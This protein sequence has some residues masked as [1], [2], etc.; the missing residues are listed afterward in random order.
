[1]K[2]YRTVLHS[3]ISG[4]ATTFV[5]TRVGI[6]TKCHSYYISNVPPY[7]CTSPHV[8]TSDDMIYHDAT[9]C[10]KLPVSYFP[11]QHGYL[12]P[13]LILRIT[14]SQKHIFRLGFLKP[15]LVPIMLSDTENNVIPGL[16]S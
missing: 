15:L 9:A 14:Q 13:H 4:E 8:I 11:Q 6:V 1:M 3:I 12:R 2:R 5:I 16:Y 7:T 10:H